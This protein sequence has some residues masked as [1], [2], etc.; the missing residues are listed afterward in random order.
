MLGHAV[1]AATDRRPV[2]DVVQTVMEKPPPVEAAKEPVAHDAP[3]PEASESVQ[4]V[5]DAPVTDGAMTV[6]RPHRWTHRIASAQQVEKNDGQGAQRNVQKHPVPVQAPER[7]D[8]HS[9]AGGLVMPGVTAGFP[10][11]V[12]WTPAPMRAPSGRPPGALPPAVRTAADEPSFA[13]D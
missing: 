6:S 11:A 12:V 7:P 8:E 9:V 4:E 13:P 3:L 1:E 5:G 10:G 2:P